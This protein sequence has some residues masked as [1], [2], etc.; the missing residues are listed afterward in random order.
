MSRIRVVIFLCVIIEAGWMAFDGTRALIV[1]DYVTP[2]S[3]P[4][5]GQ[6][7]PWSHVVSTV[8][9]NPRGTLVKLGIAF[10][11][12]AWLLL[13]AAFARGAAWSWAA[14]LAAALGALWY[15]PVGTVLSLVQLALLLAFRARLR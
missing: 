4:R 11:G 2:S 15:A 6:L 1:G 10:Y 12:I 5:Q 14:M 3:G 7:G 13:A 9:L 8:G